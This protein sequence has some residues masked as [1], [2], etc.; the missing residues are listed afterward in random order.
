MG[1]TA[2]YNCFVLQL[3]EKIAIDSIHPGENGYNFYE[4]PVLDLSV[5]Q[6]NKAPKITGNIFF[7]KY[8]KRNNN[9]KNKSK[10]AKKKYP[11]P[12]LLPQLSK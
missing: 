5:S 4:V 8:E 11:Y 2:N 1:Q 7:F 12:S 9:N 3:N 6:I 10:K